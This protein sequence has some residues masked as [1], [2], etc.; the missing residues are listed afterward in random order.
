[1]IRES[2]AAGALA[3]AASAAAAFA[4]SQRENGHGA[5]PLNAI[6]HILDGGEPPAH[7]GANRRNTALGLGIHTGACLFW[8]VVFELLFGRHAR[9][10]AG[11]AVLAGAATAA[12]AYVVDYY[13][14]HPR[15]RPGIEAYLSPRSMFA[16]YAA[17]GTGFALAAILTRARRRARRRAAEPA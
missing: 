15:F 1:L 10:S 2:L 4:C 16:V 12:T 3:S 9:Q 6:T 13:V 7:D 5:R 8:G 11:K 17:L 14:V